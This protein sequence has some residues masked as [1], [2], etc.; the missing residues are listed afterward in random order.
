MTENGCQQCGENTFSGA[1]ASSCISCPGDMVSV[2]GSSSKTDCNF[3][4]NQRIS[5]YFL[6]AAYL[7]FNPLT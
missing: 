4:E 2:A 3:G 5:F 1:R 6:F 7:L